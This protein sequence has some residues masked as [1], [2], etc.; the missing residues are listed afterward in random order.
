[1]LSFNQVLMI[2][3]VVLEVPS[4]SDDDDEDATSDDDNGANDDEDFL[5]LLLNCHR[6]RAIQSLPLPSLPWP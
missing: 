4:S 1:M 2:V 6:D 3:G 5:P